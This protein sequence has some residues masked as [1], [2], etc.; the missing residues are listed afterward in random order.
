V[1]DT[2]AWTLRAGAKGYESMTDIDTRVGPFPYSVSDDQW[3]WWYKS[4]DT[5]TARPWALVADDRMFYLWVNYN[6][7]NGQR[8]YAFG[9]IV[10]LFSADQWC[11]VVQGH[12]SSSDNNYCGG[13]FTLTHA[14]TT[15]VGGCVIYRNHIGTVM[16]RQLLPLWLFAPQSVDRYTRNLFPAAIGGVQNIPFPHPTNMGTLTAPVYMFESAL[17]DQV[18]RG[19]LPGV[20]GPTHV[21]PYNDLEVIGTGGN[22]Y[23]AFKVWA[24]RGAY[25]TY[26]SGP[27]QGQVLIDIIGPWRE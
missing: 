21:I 1:D 12:S 7:N 6:S 19:R 5:G 2:N 11:C 3:V 27:R 16:G 22:Q 9:D 23:I 17:D 4:D 25:H 18:V 8:I 24:S 10:P 20:V 13:M 26:T 14:E 15:G